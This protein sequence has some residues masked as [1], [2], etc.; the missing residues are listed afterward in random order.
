M[1]QLFI[2]KILVQKA[3][4]MCAGTERLGA[5]R[6]PFQSFALPKLN[7]LCEL[8]PSFQGIA[9]SLRG[10][11]CIVGVTQLRWCKLEQRFGFARLPA[12]YQS[13]SRAFTSVQESEECLGDT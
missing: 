4:H 3:Q 2:V 7:E 8:I 10:G 6:I 12:L 13:Q 1:R 9:V 11:Q 5:Q